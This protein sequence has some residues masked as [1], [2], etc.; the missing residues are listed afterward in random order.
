MVIDQR[1]EDSIARAKKQ[2][3]SNIIET[4]KHTLGGNLPGKKQLDMIRK[5]CEEVKNICIVE[6]AILAHREVLIGDT[7]PAELEIIKEDEK[8]HYLN[9]QKKVISIQK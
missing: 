3:L 6:S 5:H 4:K 8:K 7:E 1:D 2:F 9:V